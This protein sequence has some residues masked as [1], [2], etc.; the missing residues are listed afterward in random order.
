LAIRDAT[1]VSVLS[2]AGLRPGEVRG[3]R[4]SQVGDRTL[5]VNAARTGNRRSVRLLAP[6]RSDLDAW[7]DAG[8][9]GR[10]DGFVFPAVDSGEWS[11][12]AFEKWR[13]RV[14]A[15]ALRKAG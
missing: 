2:Y 7:R 12:N 8:G 15:P 13:R 9:D 10:P 6:L 3:L 1:V 5:V 4:W 14:F 11:A